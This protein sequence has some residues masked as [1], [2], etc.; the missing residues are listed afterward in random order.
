[1]EFSE[2]IRKRR[3]VRDFDSRP[4]APEMIE[5][6]LAAAQRGPSSGFTQGFELLV[7]AGPSETA[8]FWDAI[9]PETLSVLKG[10][11]HAPL[12]V[13]PLA[14]EAAYVERYKAPDKALV[15]RQSGADFPAPY[16]FVDTAFSAMLILLAAVDVGLGAFY[17]SIGATSKAI[18]EFRA[19]FGIPHAL[20]PIGAIA[21][22][23]PGSE[24]RPPERAL[25]RQKRRPSD[26]LI[27]RAKW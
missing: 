25:V 8:R 4:I 14:H 3:M 12:V 18:P 19:A 17:F 26:A 6:I 27:H 15:G 16:W 13:V 9:Q 23:Y 22:G 21:I 7:F 11:R 24:D 1:M 10:A 2:V 5:R 20:D